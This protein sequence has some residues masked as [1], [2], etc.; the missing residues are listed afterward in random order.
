MQLFSFVAGV[1]LLVKFFPKS[2]NRLAG[3]R[4]HS[5]TFSLSS[6]SELAPLQSSNLIDTNRNS[7]RRTRF[8]T[9]AKTFHRLSRLDTLPTKPATR[10]HFPQIQVLHSRAMHRLFPIY[11]HTYISLKQL[12]KSNRLHTLSKTTSNSESWNIN[13]RASIK[14]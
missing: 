3:W 4:I 9:S 6:V 5:L 10:L 2:T 12:W 1:F 11:L 13:L 7:A 14:M 8:P